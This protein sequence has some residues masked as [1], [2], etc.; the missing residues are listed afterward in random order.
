MEFCNPTNKPNM[1]HLAYGS[2]IP[3]TIHPEGDLDARSGE[4]NLSTDELEQIAKVDPLV[5]ETMEAAHDT[6]VRGEFEEVT[7]RNAIYLKQLARKYYIILLVIVGAIILAIVMIIVD[8]YL[9]YG[10]VVAMYGKN[11]T[12]YMPSA[13]KFGIALRV[14]ALAGFM[15]FAVKQFPEAV[16][17]S[18]MSTSMHDTFMLDP[19]GNI[20]QMW[21]W[22]NFWVTG[23]A[24]ESAIDIVC[25]TWGWSEKK[26][27]A[28][29]K[30][31]EQPCSNGSGNTTAGWTSTAISS[32]T[33]MAMMAP[34]G[35]VGI[36]VGG[37][38]A[39]FSGLSTAGIF[40]SH[41]KPE[42]CIS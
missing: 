14:P 28:V 20:E 1:A 21:G 35:G 19:A 4:P 18:Y 25:N 8:V 32:A 6:R 3:Q 22:A 24:N 37:L 23:N 27:G 36:V 31:C 29:L 11:K 2:Q 16:Y 26:G 15:G 12:S 40:S 13:L 39:I 5:K 7:A 42:N 41:H 34:M 10:S 30:S 17:I 9:R 38:S 33:Q